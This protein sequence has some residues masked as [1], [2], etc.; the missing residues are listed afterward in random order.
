MFSRK[1]LDLWIFIPI[2]LLSMVGVI[3]IVSVKPEN[4]PSHILFLSIGFLSFLFALYFEKNILFIFSAHLY[5]LGLL[6]LLLPLIF[7]SVTRGSVRWVDLGLFTI[8]PSEIIKPLI[9]LFSAFYWS[10]ISKYTFNKLFLYLLIVAPAIGLVIIQP[11]LG[12]ALI[13]MVGIS[14]SVIFSGISFK[15]LLIVGL[16]I[17]SMAP[18][19]WF[20]LHDYQHQRILNFANP[21]RDPLG[22]GYNAI[23]AKNTVGSG[24]LFGKGIGQGTQSHLAFLPEKH[25][26]FIFASYAEEFGFIGSI[27]L[28]ALYLFLYMRILT[29]SKKTDNLADKIF[30]MGISAMMFFQTM[31]NIGMNIGIMPIAGVT[32]PLISYGGSSLIITLGSLGLVCNIASGL[33]RKSIIRIS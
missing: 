12:S 6:L 1:P 3:A 19:G 14:A 21:Y 5:V 25:T 29:I 4:L 2:L 11:D 13:I 26:D 32:L 27:I 20:S 15:K 7:G 16:L 33:Q 22:T 31:V 17:T 9:V 24:I 8:Q 28:L 10:R 18:I 23:Q 30:L